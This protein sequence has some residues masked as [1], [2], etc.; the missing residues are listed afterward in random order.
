[1][2]KVEIILREWIDEEWRDWMGGLSVSY[3]EPDKT[4]LT[5]VLIDQ[6]ALYGVLARIRDLGFQLRS[7][8]IETLQD[9]IKKP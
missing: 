6:A 4:L 9:N 1:M 5:G 7:V 3:C 2:L 8:K